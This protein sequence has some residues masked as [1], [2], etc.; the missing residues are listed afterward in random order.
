MESIKL[1]LPYPE[2]VDKLP[3]LVKYCVYFLSYFL[4]LL[5]SGTSLLYLLGFSL[6][7]ASCATYRSICHGIL[8]H[9]SSI[10]S[11]RSK[12]ETTILFN[13]LN[14]ARRHS[15]FNN[16]LQKTVYFSKSVHYQTWI[17]EEKHVLHQ[18]MNWDCMLEIL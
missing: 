16:N 2:D 12:E 4:F 17:K 9:L 13:L 5:F 18:I 15:F 6:V 11:W 14:F 8:S 3:N 7:V 10:S 1:S